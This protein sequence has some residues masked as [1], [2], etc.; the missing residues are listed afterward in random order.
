MSSVYNTQLSEK[1]SNHMPG[2][3][4]AFFGIL[5]RRRRGSELVDGPIGYWSDEV[6]ERDGILLVRLSAGRAMQVQ[7]RG[8]EVLTRT[9]PIAN[10]MQIGEHPPWQIASPGC[11][12]VWIQSNAAIWHW[13]VAKGINVEGTKQWLNEAV[14][15]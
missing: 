4:A 6:S 7:L 9:V 15:V 1:G 5:A 2:Q 14:V 8:S 10:A 13:L 11:V 12:Q 3:L